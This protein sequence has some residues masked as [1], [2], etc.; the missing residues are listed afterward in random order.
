MHFLNPGIP[1]KRNG[2]A[3]AGP[4]RDRSVAAVLEGHRRT[5]T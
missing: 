4:F 2:P 1:L 3:F 5:G